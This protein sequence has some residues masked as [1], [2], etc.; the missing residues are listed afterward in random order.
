MNVV[1]LLASLAKLDIRLWLEGENLRFNAPEGVFTG[2]IR[3]QVISR[4]A[5]IIA[6]LKQARKLNEQPIPVIGRDGPLPVSYSQQRLWVLDRLNPRDVTYNMTSA[7]R[8]RGA[9]NF[10]VL[11]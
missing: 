8:I 6:F 10:A 5:E 7:L 4:K 9:L 1:D 3:E 2:E 11:E